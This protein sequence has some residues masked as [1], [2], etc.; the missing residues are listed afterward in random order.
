MVRLLLDYDGT[1]HDC[2]NIYAPAFRLAYRSLVER[3]YRREREW[4]AR[5]LEQWLGLTPTV[6]W[7]R[8]A[9]DVPERVREE[10]SGIIEG[11]MLRRTAAGVARL[12]PGVPE[13]LRRLREAGYSLILLSNCQ[14]AY[15]QAHKR[16]FHLEEYFDGFYC[17]QDYGWPEKWAMFPKIQRDFPG[18][19][20]AAGDRASDRELARRHGLPFVGCL[21]GYG[22]PG[23]L[24]GA[25]ALI[26]RPEELPETLAR[27]G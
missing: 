16:A 7:E 25:E 27:L 23:E 12:Y 10:C 11:E 20:A 24:E 15:L 6:M 9:P 1:L 2:L 4:E 5:E 3:G 8:F 18:S 26:S 22:G 14:R 19:Y 21:W 13:T 17:T